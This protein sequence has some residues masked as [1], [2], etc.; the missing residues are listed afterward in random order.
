MSFLTSTA[1]H[2]PQAAQSRKPQIF[3][4]S[5]ASTVYSF[6]LPNPDNEV[7]PGVRWGSHEQLFTPAY[8]AVQSWIH[9]RAGNPFQT[10]LG[11]T[12]SE[13]IAACL[14]GGYGMKA[15]VGVAAFEKL[16]DLGFLSRNGVTHLEIA[17][18]LE[19]P[20]RVN[21]GT[22]RYRFATQ[23]SRYLS[24][25][26]NRVAKEEPP[27]EDLSL[28]SWL[29]QF[30]GIGLKTASW[31]T[32]NWRQSDE[33]AIIDVH[34]FRACRMMG[35]FESQTLGPHYLKM[36]RL[37]IEFAKALRVRTSQLDALIWCQ[38]RTWGS[39]ARSAEAPS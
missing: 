3:A 17:K 28:R 18:V 30:P 19:E 22:V 39:L 21:G 37:F 31:I 32:R 10:R 1:F 36:E 25:T 6:A 14:L 20:L 16:R 35:L 13:E 4:V 27:T 29:L 34:L 2:H 26:L 33:V 15:E 12:L 5:Y 38:M 23:R 24:E 11:N 9:E 7:M 8:W